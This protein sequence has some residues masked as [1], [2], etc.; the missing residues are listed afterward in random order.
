MIT[1]DQPIYITYNLL[2]ASVIA[3]ANLRDIAGPKG[4][5]GRVVAI[6]TV[7]TTGVTVAASS[8][9][10]GTDAANALFATLAIPISAADAVANNAS[11]LTLDA[12]LIPADSRVVIGSGGGATAGAVNID[13]TIAWF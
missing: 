10:V 7:V 4:L 1:Y 8:V 2:A 6:A 5:T 11:L 9:V 12:N 13:V 3:D